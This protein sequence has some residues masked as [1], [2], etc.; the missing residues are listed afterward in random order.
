VFFVNNLA[1][2]IIF[3]CIVKVGTEA[4]FDIDK[5]YLYNAYKDMWL[6]K[7]SRKNVVF[8]RI[9]NI[10]FRK[11]KVKRFNSDGKENDDIITSGFVVN[12]DKEILINVY[13]N[14][15]IIPQDI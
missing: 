3:R 11:R 12:V 5:A 8:K 1:A 4:V 13:K 14:K 2:N 6:N 15:Y 9:Q 7:K 10:S